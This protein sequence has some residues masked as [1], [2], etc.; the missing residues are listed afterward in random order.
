MKVRVIKGL[1]DRIKAAVEKM[2]GVPATYEGFF[3]V[4][5]KVQGETVWEGYINQYMTD[6]GR[7]YAWAVEGETEPQFVTVRHTPSVDSPLAA[8]REWLASLAKK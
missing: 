6:Q 8:V 1:D 2:V 4:A 3:P 5:E 7:V